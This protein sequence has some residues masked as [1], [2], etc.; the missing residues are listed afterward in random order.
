MNQGFC[1]KLWIG[2]DGTVEQIEM[3]EP[4]E[5]LLGPLAG[6]SKANRHLQITDGDSPGLHNDGWWS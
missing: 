5:A 4:F 1:K 6:T 2:Q 3:T